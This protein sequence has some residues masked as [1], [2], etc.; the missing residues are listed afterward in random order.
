MPSMEDSRNRGH[1]LM[2]APSI[3]AIIQST[4][5]ALLFDEIINKVMYDNL[6]KISESFCSGL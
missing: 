6:V 1:V 5:A 2:I 4:G 3:L